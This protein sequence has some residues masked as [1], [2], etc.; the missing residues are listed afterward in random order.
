MKLSIIIPIFNEKENLPK[1]LQKIEGVEIPMEK[2]IILVDDFSMD[3]TREIVASLAGKY[4]IFLH[5]KNS[6][7]GAAVKSGLKLATGDYVIIQDADLEYDPEDY[8]KLIAELV[9][10]REV[11]YGSRNLTANQRF[12]KT[13][14]YGGKLITLTANIL[15]G[16][17][18][19]DVN[20]CYKLFKTDL[21][22]S[23]NLEEDDFSFCEEATAKVLKRGIKIKEV[24]IS[25]Y[26][27]SFSEGKKI[28]L[29]DGINGITTLLKYRFAKNK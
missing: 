18:L 8:R 12:K 10:G 14:Y 5:Q 17:R 2:E 11:V 6:G 22:K 29:R 24:P 21:L 4:K 9:N 19:T 7:K 13:Y 26:P 27:R 3:G 16:S 20:T 25:Y 15:F 28:R 23:L 1:I